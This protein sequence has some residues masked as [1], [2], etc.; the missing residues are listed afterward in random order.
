MSRILR[1]RRGVTGSPIYRLAVDVA[2]NQITWDQAIRHAQ[3][4]RMASELADGDLIDLDRQAHF[5][6]QTNPE[7]GLLIQRLTVAAARAKGFEKVYVD[8]AMN[9]VEMLE[10]AGLEQERDYYLGE[11]LRAAQ[12]VSYQTGYRRV[13]NRMARYA[14]LEHNDAEARGYL[15]EQLAI[16]R[17]E[18][19]TREDVDTAIMLADM[20]L[21]DGDRTTAHDL[22]Q[23]AARSGRRL[24]YDSAVV[25]AL[26]QL[27][28]LAVESGDL[29]GASRLL[30]QAEEAAERTVDRRLQSRVALRYGEVRYGQG[31][32]DGALRHLEVALRG[33]R[34]DEDLDIESRSLRL[35]ADCHLDLNDLEEATQY[36]R[37]LV[38]IEKRLGHQYDAGRALTDLARTSVQLGRNEEALKALSEAREFARLLDDSQL[39]IDV[40]GLLGAVLV[41]QGNEH[42]SLEA[43]DVAVRESR[44]IEDIDGE[45]RWLLGAAEAMLRFRGSAEARPVIDQARRLSRRT[46]DMLLRSEV[47]GLQGQVALVDER[48]TE[49]V[50]SFSEAASL[51]REAGNIGLQLHYLPVLARLALEDGDDEKLEQHLTEIASLA[52]QVDEPR[53][54]C[55]IHGQLGSLYQRAG[56]YDHAID[57]FGRAAEL[58]GQVGDER[59]R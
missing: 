50:H 26:L 10:Q 45:I 31:D 58:A 39:T 59:L 30:R 5:E 56:D 11:A 6:A 40:H 55:G 29:D 34:Q 49:A 4:Y 43:Y 47:E 25:N 3:S 52:D 36:L 15:A 51:A 22:Y 38:D 8:L 53:R 1:Q 33:S 19:D 16:G 20:A 44:M 9:L 46:D 23:R 14:S 21:A 24:A 54:K 37:D 18:S 57:H 13:L 17:E 7:F 42:G 12:R 48:F 27:T 32:P 41:A 2:R 28:S 35:L